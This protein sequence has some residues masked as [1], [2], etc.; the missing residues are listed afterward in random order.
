MLTTL[1]VALY[2]ALAFL[3][4]TSVAQFISKKDGEK[5][6]KITALS[7]LAMAVVTIVV[8]ICTVHAAD[9]SEK[10][11]KQTK[12]PL[13]TVK[14]NPSYSVEKSIYDNEEFVITNDGPKTKSATNVG[15][16]SFIETEYRD[17]RSHKDPIKKIIPV[18][19][20]NGVTFSSNNLDGTIAYS[21]YSGN[22]NECFFNIYKDALQYGENHQDVFVEV[23]KKNY[24][25]IDYVDI[26][27]E[28][29]HIVKTEE[30]EMDPEEFEKLKTDA[31]QLTGGK[32]IE[33]DELNLEYLIS[34]CLKDK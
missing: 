20:F 30:T 12:Q 8:G 28:K 32:P 10:M 33:I 4:V 17:I 5:F 13:F 34:L 14:I 25:V 11:E 16:Y 6:Q 27:G 21:M 26:F 9:R 31:Y 22:N 15:V 7:S 3:F 24:Y 19:Y 1:N 18:I 29:H 23:Q 2:C